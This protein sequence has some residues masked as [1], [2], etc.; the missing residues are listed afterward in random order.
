MGAVAQVCACFQAELAAC[1]LLLLD[2]EKLFAHVDHRLFED[3]LE[4][5]D[6]SYAYI[7]QKQLAG[8]LLVL[9]IM[10]VMWL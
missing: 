3:A 8:G 4:R 5:Q 10:S 9:S 2:P 6:W 7:A 1:D